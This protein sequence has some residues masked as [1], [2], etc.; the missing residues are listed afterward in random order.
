[1]E[2]FFEDT[3]LGLERRPKYGTNAGFALRDEV[4]EEEQGLGMAGSVAQAR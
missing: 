2:C 1:M 4:E 3:V